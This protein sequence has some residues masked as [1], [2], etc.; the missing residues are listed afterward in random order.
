MVVGP[1]Q[2]KVREGAG[3]VD[4][5]GARGTLV[6]STDGGDLH[7]KAVPHDDW[8]LASGSGT[9]RIELPPAARFDLDALTD[10]GSLM[11]RRDDLEKPGAGV[12]RLAERANGGGRRIEVRTE[13]GTIVVR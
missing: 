4:V 13:T 3:N 1:S 8:R 6:V 12:H 11:I 2:A 10:S 7:V 5:G 9:I